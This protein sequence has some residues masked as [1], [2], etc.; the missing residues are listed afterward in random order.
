MKMRPKMICVYYEFLFALVTSF[1]FSMEFRFHCFFFW[2]ASVIIKPNRLTHLFAQKH[3][4]ITYI[5][6]NY[7]LLLHVT[8][9][10]FV[11]FQEKTREKINI[12]LREQF[13]S[14]IRK[15]CPNSK[16]ENIHFT[17]MKINK[18]IFYFEMLIFNFPYF[19]KKKWKFFSWVLSE[20]Q[21]WIKSFRMLYEYWM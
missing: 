1:T 17:I 8:N 16:I 18:L 19:S 3:M 20:S 21:T 4:T 7:N 9:P 14:M 5:I 6:S 15:S 10:N 12:S 13:L 2:F 11:P